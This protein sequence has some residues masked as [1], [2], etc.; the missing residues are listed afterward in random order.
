MRM[1]LRA[2][3]ALG[4]VLTLC[5]GGQAWAQPNYGSAPPGPGSD[6]LLDLATSPTVINT[7][8]NTDGTVWNQY[9]VGFI[10]S[11]TTSTITFSFRNDPGYFGLDNVSAVD[12]VT[13]S[14]NLLTN[15]DFSA[16]T[17]GLAV[18]TSTCTSVTP[19]GW[20][21]YQ[22]P[23]IAGQN[24]NSGVFDGSSGPSVVGL[25][26]LSGSSQFWGDGAFYAYDSLAQSFQTIINDTYT[27]SFWLADTNASAYQQLDTTGNASDVNNGQGNGHDVVLYGPAAVYTPEPA[28]LALLGVGLLG[29]GLV[30]RRVR[31]QA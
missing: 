24:T 7:V 31:S 4:V 15:G 22:E 6:V 9:S 30:R 10:A 25:S 8:T 16:A 11:Q 20:Q 23:G 1:F 18:C 29:M 2:A 28:S 26:P 17:P 21:F 5:V 14:G 13:S 27:I 12:T 19:V 3:A